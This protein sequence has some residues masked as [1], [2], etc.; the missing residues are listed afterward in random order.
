MAKSL[1]KTTLYLFILRLL[2]MV[3]TVVTVTFSA[4]YFGVSMEKD[5]WVLTLTI[6]TTVT[7]AVWGP[8]NEVFRTKFVFI[9]EQEGAEAAVGKTASLVGFIFWVTILMA[10][11]MFVAAPYMSQSMTHNMQMGAAALFVS[12]LLLQLPSLMINELTNIGISILNAYDVYYIPEIVGFASGLVNLAAII[13]FANSIGIY[14]LLIGTYFGIIVLFAVVLYFL[15]KKGI[16]IWGRL[17]SFK[18]GDVKVFLLFALPF[19]F[20]YFVGQINTLFEKYLAGMLG[21]GNISSVEY[22]RQFI[23]VLQS[24]LSSVLTTI[25]VPVLAKQFIN[26]HKEEFNRTILDNLMICMLIYLAACVFLIGSS[27]PLCDFFFNRG[28]VSPEA[29]QNIILLTKLYGIA[30]FGVL[31]YLIMGMSLLASNK[32]KFYATVGVATQIAVLAINFLLCPRYGVFVFPIALGS[33]HFVAGAIMFWQITYIDIKNTL[34]YLFRAVLAVSG[35]T[36]IFYVFND[37]V[38]YDVSFIRLVVV[39]CLFGVLLPASAL[40]LGFDVKAYII[41]IKSKINHSI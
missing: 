22:A 10:I 7:S 37:F 34:G 24:V 14:S 31:L 36:A 25:M 26:R 27:T 41:K 11:G 3:I 30:F 9:R 35:V 21:S 23:T 5:I 39:G 2:R 28:K 15:H 29:L 16:S 18:W 32:G 19:F 40:M 12:L 38:A 1:K 8:I 33:V 13:L 20:P 4:K 6:I 17:V